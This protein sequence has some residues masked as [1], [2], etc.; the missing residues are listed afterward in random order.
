MKRKY[1]IWGGLALLVILAVWMLGLDRNGTLELTAPDTTPNNSVVAVVLQNAD[2]DEQTL[3]LQ[4]GETKSVKLQPGTWLVDGSAS[5]LRS[6]DVVTVEGG[7][8][9]ELTTPS[10]ERRGIRQ[11][12]SDARNCPVVVAGVVYSYNCNGEG[13]IYRHNPTARGGSSNVALFNERPFGVLYPYKEGLLEAVQTADNY[14]LN[15][16]DLFAQRVQPLALPV[17]IQGLLQ[18][19]Q[20]IVVTPAEPGNSRFALLFT[21]HDKLYVFSDTTDIQPVELRPGNGQT[22]NK[23]GRFAHLS[24]YGEHAVLFIGNSDHVGEGQDTLEETTDKPANLPSY[25]FEYDKAGKLL[26]TIEIPAEDI[27]TLIGLQKVSD[28]FYALSSPGQVG[29]YY[30]GKD[31]LE[32]VYGFSEVAS[33]V[34]LQG[35]AYVQEGGVLY[36]FTPKANGL[37]GLHGLFSSSDITV[38]SIYSSPDGVLFTGFPTGVQSPELNIYQL[39][40]AGEPDE[41]PVIQREPTLAGT[42]QLIEVGVTTMQV[43]ALRIALNTFLENHGIAVNKAVLNNVATAPYFR[44]S[45]NPVPS[46]SFSLQFDGK[47]KVNAKLE[48]VPLTTV[49]LFLSDPD[50][51]VQVY[52]SGPVSS[53]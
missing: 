6:V 26:S 52:D 1:L 53:Q 32:A 9:S 22:L 36:E 49:R 13:I 41:A 15:Y 16:V 5:G 39:L 17:D 40:A 23:E 37:F 2:E 8:T 51:N 19:E 12:G 43:D 14:E 21:T 35:V 28:D 27:P 29:F 7:K 31:K 4:P 50:N 3:K 25:V 11:R 45:P 46:L 30:R 48:Y 44:D 20:P 33:I 42:E 34:V 38:S 24:F 10:G 18:Q 47:E